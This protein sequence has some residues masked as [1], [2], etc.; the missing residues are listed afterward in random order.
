LPSAGVFDALIVRARRGAGQPGSRRL[1]GGA[2]PRPRAPFT[3]IPIA[4]DLAYDRWDL[5]VD[6]FAA[7]G[8]SPQD[9]AALFG[10][11][12]AAAL[13]QYVLTELEPID[14]NEN[15]IICSKR[16]PPQQQGWEAY[17]FHTR[18]D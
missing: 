8:L 18:D 6:G 11:E 13:Q 14:T 9:A 2:S 5:T 7:E 10:F 15:G 4:S 12:D 16:S 3:A 1:R 17:C